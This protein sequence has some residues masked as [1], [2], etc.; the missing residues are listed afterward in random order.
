MR[1]SKSSPMPD[2]PTGRTVSEATKALEE[3]EA[4]VRAEMWEA[5]ERHP[6]NSGSIDVLIATVRRATLAEVLEKVKIKRNDY[7]CIS[8]ASEWVLCAEDLLAA[9]RGMEEGA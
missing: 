8:G 4:D 7:A 3:A 1:T 6:V 9:L 2:T 5:A